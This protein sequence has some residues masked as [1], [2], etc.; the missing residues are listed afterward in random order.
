MKSF[1]F[2]SLLLFSVPVLAQNDS[3]DSGSVIIHKDARIDLLVK[4]QAQINEETTREARRTG[5]GFRLMILNTNNRDEAINAKSTVYTYF[6]ELKTY[7]AYQSPYFKLKAGNFKTR[8]EAIDYQK[9]M[10]N[11]FPKGVFVIPD[12]IEISPDKESRNP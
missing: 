12:T 9:R 5:K 4:K 3:A 10:N 2:A 11:L 1:L 6:P 8:E 7:L